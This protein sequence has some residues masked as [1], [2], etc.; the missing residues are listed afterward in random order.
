MLII[1]GT[2]GNSAIS[3]ARAFNEMID[4]DGIIIT[5]LDGTAK[6]GS[7][8]SIAY[9]LRLPILFIG[10]GEQPDDL[11]PFDKYAFV[12]G[13]LDAIFADETRDA[14]TPT[15]ASKSAH[16]DQV[17]SV[18][19]NEAETLHVS[20]EA[21]ESSETEDDDE[22]VF[23]GPTL[24]QISRL[25]ALEGEDRK[26]LIACLGADNLDMLSRHFVRDRN[27]WDDHKLII[28]E[29]ALCWEIRKRDGSL[30]HSYPLEG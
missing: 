8:F 17:T 1:D 3:Q 26:R 22:E 30:L 6:G 12:D 13:F 16:P 15:F 10:V 23:E 25:H 29:E 9:A 5:K 18:P 27:T 7:I 4:I 24:E 11:I 2:Q 20:A 28:N 14:N 21:T 19:A